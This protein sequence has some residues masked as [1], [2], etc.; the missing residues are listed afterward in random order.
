LI[1]KADAG[2]DG[3]SPSPREQRALT[4]AVAY[5]TIDANP[6]WTE[7]TSSDAWR[8]ATA[9]NAD[10]WIQPIDIETGSIA[11]GRGGRVETLSGGHRL[12]DERFV[13]KPPLELHVPFGV[14]IDPELLE[15]AYRT[16]L[17]PAE[18][19]GPRSRR[20]EVAMRWVVKSWWNTASISDEDRLVLLKT[21]SEALTASSRS[22]E[23]ARELR[24]IFE[25]ALEQEGDG[26][27]VDELLWSREEPRFVRTWA[28]GTEEL[29]AIEHWY[30]A[31]SDA[32]NAVLHNGQTQLPGYSEAGSPYVGPLVEI[33]DRVMREA[34]DVE[35]GARGSPSVWRRGLTRTTFHAFARLA[36]T[37]GET[38]TQ[39]EVP[40]AI[41]QPLD[42]A[43]LDDS[44]W[45]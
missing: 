38:S 45:F 21:A 37:A 2:A 18:A 17:N 8:V 3:E 11:F 7:E 30:M 33:A 19:I 22:N 16:I 12:G 35:L 9:D 41:M 32:R 15:A 40:G 34:I 43:D 44:G 39:V 29:P 36:G 27:G 4:E 25:G 20:V 14:R 13:I 26:L 24:R 28:G 10:L 1:V 5:A 23:A 42:D 31:F 6:F